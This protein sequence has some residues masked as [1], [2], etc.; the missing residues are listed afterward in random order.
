MGKYRFTN[1]NKCTTLVWDVDNGEVGGGM[2]YM[3]TFYILH[4]IKKKT[5]SSNYKAKKF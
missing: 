5:L 4:S 1:D 3:G 2:W